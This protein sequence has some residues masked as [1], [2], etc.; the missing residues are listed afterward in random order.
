MPNANEDRASAS[1]IISVKLLDGSSETTAMTCSSVFFFLF[2]VLCCCIAV[3][4]CG[5]M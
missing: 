3:S 5:L 4:G 1:F 2:K